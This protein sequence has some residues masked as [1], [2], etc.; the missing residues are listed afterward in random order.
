MFKLS[1]VFSLVMTALVGLLFLADY[2]AAPGPF[3]ANPR[4]LAIEDLP[5][6]SLPS[7]LSASTKVLLFYHPKCPC[8]LATIR[9]LNRLSSQFSSHVRIVA[10]AYQPQG[11]PNS[12]IESQTTRILRSNELTEVFVDPDGKTS[13]SFGALTS[14]HLLVYDRDNLLAFSG[15]ITHLRGHEGDSC[16]SS[17]FVRCVR[18]R[19]TEATRWPVFG[20]AITGEG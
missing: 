10:F 4:E 5:A 3:A 8:T 14:G 11:E 1:L 17:E 20:C 2:S 13:K 12:W 15:G 18:G 9:N 16:A 7:D 6:G 19:N